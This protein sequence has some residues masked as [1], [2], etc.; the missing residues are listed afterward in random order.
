LAPSIRIR[1]RIEI[2]S[3][4]RIRIETNNTVPDPR[5]NV[6]TGSARSDPDH[7][8]MEQ[9]VD[10]VYEADPAVKDKPTGAGMALTAQGTR[11]HFLR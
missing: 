2:K 4:I 1:I 6:N 11:N 9:P 5:I 3:Q 7:I 10:M 8:I